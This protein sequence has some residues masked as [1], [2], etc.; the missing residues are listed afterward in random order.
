MPK[1]G[2]IPS[3]SMSMSNLPD[4]GAQGNKD[5]GK[6]NDG[7][8]GS[9]GT[10]D[11]KSDPYLGSWKTKDDASKGLQELQKKLDSQGTEVGSLRKQNR[12]LFDAFRDVQ[13]TQASAGVKDSDPKSTS[14]DDLQGVLAE[15]GKLDFVEDA[16]ASKKGAALMQQAIGLTAKM[17]KEDTL[18][19]AGAQVQDLLQE[20][21]ANVMMNKFYEAN[22]EFSGLQEEGAF[23]A[24]KDSNPLHDDFSA[25]Y[26]HQAQ[27]SA[28]KISELEA[29][30]EEA[31]N[32][33]NLAGGDDR[34]SK[35]F[36][37]PG[38]DLRGGNVIK[39]K[40]V[41]ELKQ[42]ALQTIRNMTGAG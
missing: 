19:E 18:S 41:S 37:K 26:E 25:Y 14:G 24:L 8:D 17:V 15:Y 33:A 4:E 21:D 32:V 38:G 9:A 39:P 20:K 12:E 31:K 5:D 22:P 36:S 40:T 35:V 30:L 27:E 28:S 10:K 7:K 13:K 2:V 34:T 11:G 3:G 16:D 1:K 29:A 42:S 23:Q 6:T